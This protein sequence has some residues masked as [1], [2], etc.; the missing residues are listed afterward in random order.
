MSRCDL[1]LWAIDLEGSWYIKHCVVKVCTKFERNRLIFDRVIGKIKRWTFFW[2]QCIYIETT[3]MMMMI[4]RKWPVWRQ[5]PRWSRTTGSR[6]HWAGLACRPAR[7]LVLD[8]RTSQQS[9][10]YSSRRVPTRRSSG[11][12]RR[13]SSTEPRARQRRR[14]LGTSRD[15]FCSRPLPV[16]TGNRRRPVS[17]RWCSS[18]HQCCQK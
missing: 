5:I 1:D 13:T 16:G 3:M 2:T 8:R 7:Q 15:S 18:L 17:V 4:N 14:A 11:L 12:C 10:S 9:E 6:R